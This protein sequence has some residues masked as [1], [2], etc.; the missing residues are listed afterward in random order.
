MKYLLIL[1]LLLTP[2]ICS[3]NEKGVYVTD[4]ML[5]DLSN[6][7]TNKSSG[8]KIDNLTTIRSIFIV[9]IGDTMLFKYIYDIDM[10]MGDEVDKKTLTTNIKEGS[11]YTSESN[12]KM[13][14][15]IVDRSSNYKRAIISESLF[16]SDFRI[17]KLKFS[18]SSLQ[19]ID[20]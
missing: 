11:K 10:V 19:Y 6:T 17:V 12:C 8:L 3:A 4:Q 15:S 20:Y 2:S 16:F 9:G 1:A 18:C 13:L 7:L 5:K 14:Q